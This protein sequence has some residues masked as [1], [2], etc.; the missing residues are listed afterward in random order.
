MTAAE[1]AV[2]ADPA[3]GDPPGAW[4]MLAI[5]SAGVLLA[6]APWFSSGAV[7]PLLAAEWQPTGF[8]LSMLTV[9]VQLGF[10]AAALLLAISGAAD[11]LPGRWLFAGGAFV[12]AAANL[13]FA[14]V[15]TDP[16]SALPFRALTGAGIAAVYP[17]A[18]KLVAG[19]FRA[20]R[21]LA[22]G[23]VIG[24]I[25]AG[26]ALPHLFRAVGALG[27]A[28]WRTIVTATSAAAVA[29]GLLALLLARPG[30][31]DVRAP[32]F[33][34]RIAAAAF[35]ER[36][37]RLANFGYLGHM[38]E[39]FAMWTWVPLFLAASFSAAGNSDPGLAALAS[40]AVIGA[41]WVGCSVGGL[42]ADRFG[43]TALT[44]GALAVSGTCSL[45]IGFLFG[46][47][48]ALVVGLALV[49]GLTVAADSPQFS[50]AVSE[51]APAGTAGSALAIQTAA[52]FT[53]TA[54]TILAVGTI[55]AAD[56]GGWRLAFGALAVGPALG[57]VAMWRLRGLPEAVRMA[58][59]R[60]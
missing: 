47:A 25:A 52:G 26:S 30:P 56:G 57:I 40:F 14:W 19:W 60:R 29:G 31:F 53:L 49:W 8:E 18:M 32:R 58:G 3:V 21:G 41:G 2:A 17:V 9:A 34:L 42:V 27:G 36:G 23:M 38:W 16:V 55:D 39:L 20:R 4:R 37:V 44:M 51:L 6:E 48:P 50:A 11:V 1:A 15:A 54:I 12:T 35:R 43:R 45:A 7:A 10:A 28:D 13:G 24:A 33:S 5:L 46:A 59:G 22:L